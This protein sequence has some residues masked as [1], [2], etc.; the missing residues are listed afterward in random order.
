MY[1]DSFQ[2]C[3]RCDLSTRD[4]SNSSNN[5]S[6]SLNLLRHVIHQI[7]LVVIARCVQQLQFR[8]DDVTRKQ[9]HS[10][11]WG[12]EPETGGINNVDEWLYRRL[13]CTRSCFIAFVLNLHTISGVHSAR[14]AAEFITT[15]IRALWIELSNKSCREYSCSLERVSR[16]RAT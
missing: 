5:Q 14:R 13:C 16:P 9:Q 2:L 6:K 3:V 1:V 10:R 4:T 11:K 12:I 15:A 8:C 7:A